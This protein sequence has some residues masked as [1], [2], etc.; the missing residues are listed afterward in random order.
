VCR[1]SNGANILSHDR[2]SHTLPTKVVYDVQS[3]VVDSPSDPMNPNVSQII[4]NSIPVSFPMFNEVCE[5]FSQVIAISDVYPV[6][7]SNV[8]ENDH[9]NVSQNSNS[10]DKIPIQELELADNSTAIKN[11]S[12][13]VSKNSESFTLS[14]DLKVD[15]EKCNTKSTCS[16]PNC[17][18]SVSLVKPVSHIDKSTFKTVIQFK[19]EIISSANANENSPVIPVENAIL[20]AS[21]PSTSKFHFPSEIVTSTIQ[22]DDDDESLQSFDGNEVVI[23]NVSGKSAWVVIC[24][25]GEKCNALIDTG[26]ALTILKSSFGSEIESS[27]HSV[28]SATGHKLH[29]ICSAV[30]NFEIG[31]LKTKRKVYVWDGLE[32]HIIGYDI[33]KEYGSNVNLKDMKLMLDNHVIPLYTYSEINLISQINTLTDISKGIYPVPDVVISQIIK[34]P[35]EYREQ[36]TNLFQEFA[37]LFRTDILGTS[38]RFQHE[39]HLTDTTPVRLMPYRISPALYPKVQEKIQEMLDK[40]VIR[41][42]TSAYS[43]PVVIVNKKDGSIRLCLD[44][45]KVNEKTRP[46]SFPLPLVQEVL[47]ALQGAKYFATLDFSNGFW[48]IPMRECD[49]PITAFSV[50]NGHYECLKM[51][52]GQRNA[53]AT[54]SRC[55]VE[56]FKPLLNHG[57]LVFVDDITIYANSTPELLERLKKVFEII[58]SDNL[59]LNPKKCVFFE[60]EITVLGHRVSH[61]GT[62]PM[63]DKIKAIEEWREP[64]TKKGVRSFLGLAGYYRQYVSNFAKIAAPLHKL[65]GKNTRWQWTEREQKSFFELKQILKEAPVLKIFDP[66]RPI[67]ID[68]DASNYAIGAVLVQTDEEGNEHP[69]AYYSRCLSKAESNYCTTR[70]ELLIIVCALRHWRHYI[71]G[72]KIVVRSDHSSLSWIKS[73]KN[74]EQQMARWM[75]VISQYDINIQHRPG[76]KSMNADALSRRPCPEGCTYC[77]R[78]EEREKESQVLMIRIDSEVDWMLEQSKDEDLAKVIQWKKDD[79]KPPWESVSGS[80]PT[81]KR[82]WREY[83]SLTLDDGILKRTFYKPVGENL[84]ILVPRQCRTDIVKMIH[85]QGHFGCLRT[86]SSLRDRFYWPSWK[87]DV[88]KHVSKCIPCIQRKGPHVKPKLPSKKYLSSQPFERLSMDITGP[89][90]VTARGNKYILVVSDYFTKWCEAIPLP[91]QQ[92]ITIADALV[93][94]VT[95]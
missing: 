82:L 12:V 58:K 36:A 43:S 49:I 75:E 30:V 71:M 37:E 89:L 87:T 92:A 5:N 35:D 51:P 17:N 69:I 42:S 22:S 74:P 41:N 24:V 7:D 85:E 40:G 61:D 95:R 34:L 16:I 94:V 59:T 65:T 77:S 15:V 91:D 55:M 68:T 3:H 57:V 78:R 20:S 63:D 13:N 23:C 66:S 93:E 21:I 52:Q 32:S 83:T 47:D 64:T 19:E 26:S 73:F 50:Q 1:K 44:Y 31:D 80:C 38:K 8:S 45:R 39:I 76:S 29:K 81:L 33:L 67:I 79:V 90:N 6:Y 10:D 60:K 88:S 84:Q 28:R 70:R 14:D 2:I 9:S 72:T 4:P 11:V 54:F 86:Q 56:L 25:N 53:T 27:D 48:Q 18:D 46:E 62:K